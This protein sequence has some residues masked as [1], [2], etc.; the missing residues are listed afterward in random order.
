MSAAGD[1][2]MQYFKSEN[3][4]WMKPGDSP[5]SQADFAVNEYLEKHLLVARPDYGWMSEETED[6]KARLEK[7]RIFVVDPIDG[8]RGFI[9]GSDKWCI[10]VAIVENGKPVVGVLQCPVL[11][12][13]Y[14]AVA[15]VNTTLNGNDISV[16]RSSKI[17][18]VTGSQKI[19]DLVNASLKGEVAAKQFIPSLAYRIAMVANAQIDVAF[20]RPGAHEWDIAAADLILSNAG[21]ALVDLQ[22]NT[23]EYNCKNLR[24]EALLATPVELQNSAIELAKSAGILH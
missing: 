22:G 17:K 12:E 10:S 9:N 19:N 18:Q 23:L 15:G 2:A 5:V 24:R 20:A 6:T 16:T 7:Q 21:G 1:I 13:Q 3:Q 11:D 8:T 4:V 14:C